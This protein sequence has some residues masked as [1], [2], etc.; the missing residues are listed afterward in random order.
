MDERYRSIAGQIVTRN[1]IESHSSLLSHTLLG[2][3]IMC[4]VWFASASQLN[5][6]ILALIIT[7]GL[8]VSF[9]IGIFGW[10]VISKSY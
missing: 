9:L 8:N 1:Y 5:A 10:R 2:I 6:G 4:S 3:W 7:N